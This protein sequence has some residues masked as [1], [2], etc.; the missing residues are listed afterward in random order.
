ME[1]LLKRL[2]ENL[3]ETFESRL[4]SVFLYGS[5][6][7]EEYSKSFSDINL[8]VVIK[9]L[10]ATDLKKAHSFTKE[11]T[12]KSKYLPIFM[13][14]EEWFNSC[15]VYSIEYSDIKDRYKILHGE[16]LIDNLNIEKKYLRLQCEQE[17]KNLLIRLRQIYLAKASDKK[18]I[19]NLI[20]TS[21]KAFMVIFRTVLRLSDEQVP[22]GHNDVIK[23]FAEKIKTAD[24]NF[25][26]NLFLKILEFRANERILK[27][28][29][30]EDVVQKLIDST[31]YVLKYVDKIEI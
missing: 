28:N 29:E 15:D 18:S 2:I 16:N 30:I 7:T 11:F 6:A 13:D 10:H 14:K 5:C 19:K 3:N 24:I 20:Q 26:K 31:N 17:V 9:D 27:D 1:K 4:S 22:N 21:S 8:M 23:L 12:K 25:D